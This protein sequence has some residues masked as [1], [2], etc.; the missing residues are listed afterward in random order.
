MDLRPTSNAKMHI[1]IL[2]V[3]LKPERFSSIHGMNYY[4]MPN[5]TFQR[6]LKAGNWCVLSR[7]FHSRRCVEQTSHYYQN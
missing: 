3:A 1:A 7:S 4:P 2:V 5:D 6:L